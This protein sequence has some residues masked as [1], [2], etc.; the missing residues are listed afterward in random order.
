MTSAPRSETVFARLY[1]V[2]EAKSD[3]DT[4]LHSPTG[5]DRERQ[6]QSP[7]R[8]ANS[9]ETYRRDLS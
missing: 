3:S 6:W 4:T 8:E 5:V 9:A 1:R 2:E 7:A